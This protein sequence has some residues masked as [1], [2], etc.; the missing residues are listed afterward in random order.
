MCRE[1]QCTPRDCC[2]NESVLPALVRQV[3]EAVEMTRSHPACA[4]G[5]APDV[6]FVEA[7]CQTIASVRQPLVLAHGDALERHD[8][9]SWIRA[10]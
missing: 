3:K 4:S 8:S 1:K 10:N 7:Q 5:L 2:R 9:S 6:N